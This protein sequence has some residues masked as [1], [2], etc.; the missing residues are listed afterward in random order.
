VQTPVQFILALG[1][2]PAEVTADTDDMVLVVATL[3]ASAAPVEKPSRTIAA[4][5]ISAAFRASRLTCIAP[6]E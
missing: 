1:A 2:A 4:I 3:M 5:V 6:P